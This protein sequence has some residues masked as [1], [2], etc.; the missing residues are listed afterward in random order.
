MPGP[1]RA[2]FVARV[3]PIARRYAERTRIPADVLVGIAAHESNFG[4]AGGN[5]LFGIK[6]PGATYRTH[7]VV[8]GKRVDMDDSFRTYATPEAAFDDFV[9]LVSSGRYAGAWNNLQR[10]GD[11]RGFLRGINNAGYATDPKWA[12][13]IASF[14]AGTIAPL[15]GSAEGGKRVGTT[16]TTTTTTGGGKST[17]SLEGRRKLR[18]R[19]QAEL[20]AAQ[21]EL[22]AAEATAGDESDWQAADKAKARLPGLRSRVTA[23]RSSLNRAESDLAK[24]EDEAGTGAGDKTTTVVKETD[25]GSNLTIQKGADGRVWGI[26]PRTG[27]V[28]DLGLGSDADAPMTPAQSDASARGWAQLQVAQQTQAVAL[29]REQI[30]Q[31]RLDYDQAKTF[32]D[33][34]DN[35]PP[36][37]NVGGTWYTAGLEPGGIAATLSKKYGFGFQP[38]K[39]NIVDVAGALGRPDLNK[40]VLAGPYGESLNQYGVKTGPGAPGVAPGKEGAAPVGDGM[41]ISPES[42]AAMASVPGGG[43]Q[44]VP[45]DQRPRMAAA[46]PPMAGEPGGPSLED[47]QANEQPPRVGMGA[48]P[49]SRLAAAATTGAMGRPQPPYPGDVPATTPLNIPAPPAPPAGP[50][51]GG[52][53]PVQAGQESFPPPGRV[54]FESEAVVGAAGPLTGPV[55]PKATGAMPG[56]GPTFGDPRLAQAV[57]RVKAAAASQGEQIS[58]EEALDNA[59]RY[60]A[61][62]GQGG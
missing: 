62:T 35:M 36:I 43:N 38:Q 24:A 27:E 25:A 8:G 46:Q 7:E 58:D 5:M 9:D 16:T 41:P 21:K 2:A 3:Y 37:V 13:K 48:E 14:S 31:G 33:H 53:F 55:A 59:R 44:E 49:P 61:L 11:W 1:D 10:T 45:A 56:A 23:A 18:D 34:I 20:D 17:A 42:S 12:D 57:A 22:S 60:L 47:V 26:D 30:N 29:M 50:S 52:G 32:L 28:H 51:F 6:G 54:P 19:Y 40:N 15:V 4:N 39:A